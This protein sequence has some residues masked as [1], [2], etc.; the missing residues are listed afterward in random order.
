MIAKFFTGYSSLIVLSVTFAASAVAAQQLRIEGAEGTNRMQAAP[1]GQ[2]RP[3]A[4]AN[5]GGIGIAAQKRC[6]A[7]A[8]AHARTC[9]QTRR[10]VAISK[11]QRPATTMVRTALT[12][13]A[14]NFPKTE[15][16]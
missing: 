15:Q 16:A 3:G 11:P 4:L 8:V 9:P 10:R 12:M 2:N 1:Q 7:A 14:L 5:P 6:S 13:G